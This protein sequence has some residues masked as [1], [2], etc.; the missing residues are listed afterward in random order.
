[1]DN[2]NS[3]PKKRS[4]ESIS[5]LNEGSA[6]L[7][8]GLSDLGVI[9]KTLAA[10]S[11]DVAGADFL[12]EFITSEKEHFICLH[13]NAQNRVKAYDVIHIGSLTNSIVHP[14]E[15]LRSAIIASAASVIFI[16]N[17]PSGEPEPSIDDIELTNRLCKAFSIVG[18]NVLDHI[19]ISTGGY[20]S[21]KQKGLI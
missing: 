8:R 15:V 3:L 14:R 4:Q 9:T 10:I 13:L 7:K 11:E 1:M 12:N 6:L 16:H 18:I 5:K 17:H 2:N 20:F 19:I 21:F